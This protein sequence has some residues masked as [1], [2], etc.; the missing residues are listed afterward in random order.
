MYA[1]R[2]RVPYLCADLVRDDEKSHVSF[3][4]LRILSYAPTNLARR[5]RLQDCRTAP[6]LV[7][8]CRVLASAPKEPS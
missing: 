5:R 6:E 3:G 8:P 2:L 7:D 1:A 4:K